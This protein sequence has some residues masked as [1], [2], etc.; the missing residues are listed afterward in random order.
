MHHKVRQKILTELEESC[1]DFKYWKKSVDGNKNIVL[2]NSEFDHIDIRQIERVFNRVKY[3]LY[4]NITSE[5]EGEV[6][7]IVKQYHKD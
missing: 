1:I 3:D 6:T 7:V 2:K 4:V 5:K